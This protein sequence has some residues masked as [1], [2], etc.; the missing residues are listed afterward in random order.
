MLA[1]LP[2]EVSM[3]F[4]QDND[5]GCTLFNGVSDM[6]VE[7]V[8]GTIVEQLEKAGIP[9]ER[10]DLSMGAMFAE[11]AYLIHYTAR[12]SGIAVT[13]LVIPQVGADSWAEEYF[14]FPHMT[15]PDAEMLDWFEVQQHVRAVMQATIR[16]KIPV[17]QKCPHC[18]KLEGV[19]GGGKYEDIRGRTRC[20][21]CHQLW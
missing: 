3:Q 19:D 12:K 20:K 7:K 9:Y 4:T 15:K 6:D 11:A 18:G 14:H 5:Y 13:I 1:K 8:G 17:T 10:T 2:T 16:A 21:S